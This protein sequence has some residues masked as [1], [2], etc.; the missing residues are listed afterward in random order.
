[1]SKK[2]KKKGKKKKLSD[3]AGAKSLKKRINIE[4]REAKEGLNRYPD[5]IMIQREFK[6]YYEILNRLHTLLLTEGLTPLAR[7]IDH[8][9]GK[10]ARRCYDLEIQWGQN[11]AKKAGAQ[12][13]IADKKS[14]EPGQTLG[15]NVT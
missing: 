2:S 13:I 8:K 11:L 9:R 7:K 6:K 4:I 15:I 3:P 1:M 12:L 14:G 10:I 5:D